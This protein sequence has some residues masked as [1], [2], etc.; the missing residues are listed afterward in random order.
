MNNEELTKENEILHKRI[1]NLVERICSL[2]HYLGMRD[3]EQK[4]K[5]GEQKWDFF[6]VMYDVLN[7]RK[8][9]PKPKFRK[10]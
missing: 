5:G 7:R 4:N 9:Q 2:E 6:Q 10:R 8:P 1:N 3:H